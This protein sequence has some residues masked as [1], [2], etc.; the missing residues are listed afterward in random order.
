MANTWDLRRWYRQNPKGLQLWRQKKGLETNLL[1]QNIITQTVYRSERK[2]I[3]EYLQLKPVNILE[4]TIYKNKTLTNKIDQTPVNYGCEA[5]MG[6]V[7]SGWSGVSALWCVCGLWCRLQL[8]AHTSHSSTRGP[9]DSFAWERDALVGCCLCGGLRPNPPRWLPSNLLLCRAFGCW[10]RLAHSPAVA[11]KSWGCSSH[12]LML[13]VFIVDGLHLQV[14][15]THIHTCL[16]YTHSANHQP[17]PICTHA[18]MDIHIACLSVF[19]RTLNW[20]PFNFNHFFS[21][22]L[23][24]T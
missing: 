18:C 24:L 15:D 10:R 6:R 16:L 5:M 7:R 17:K 22:T 8:P 4:W 1:F 13:S 20:L 2:R 9:F 14:T 21:L 12:P 23:T 11:F 3:T 19:T